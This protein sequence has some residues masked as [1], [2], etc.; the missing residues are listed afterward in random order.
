MGLASTVQ[1]A[2][3]Y[4]YTEDIEDGLLNTPRLSVMGD[5]ASSAVV[6]N[7]PFIDSGQGENPPSNSTSHS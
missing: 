4:S 6:G 1:V 7:G 3:P 5:V 2:S